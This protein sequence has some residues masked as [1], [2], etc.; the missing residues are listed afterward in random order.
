MES[1]DRTAWEVLDAT[2]DDWENLQQIFFAVCCE[3]PDAIP[4]EQYGPVYV[5][6]HLPRLREVADEVVRLVE[7]GLLEAREEDVDAP[8]SDLTDRSYVWRAWFA[9]TMKGRA[10]WRGAAAVYGD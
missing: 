10:A 2:A 1:L 5:P 3:V 9:M 7:A 8:V 6:K 4:K